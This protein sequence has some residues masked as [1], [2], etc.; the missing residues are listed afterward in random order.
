M[1]IVNSEEVYPSL[2]ALN[3]LGINYEIV[4]NDRIAIKMDSET[5]LSENSEMLSANLEHED[6]SLSYFVVRKHRIIASGNIQ[7]L[8]DGNHVCDGPFRVFS[9]V[10]ISTVD[11]M[12]ASQNDIGNLDYLNQIMLETT[13]KGTTLK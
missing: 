8:P 6:K 3:E 1:I 2:D 5:K 12:S 13:F 10:I 7:E 9:K 11:Y 4:D